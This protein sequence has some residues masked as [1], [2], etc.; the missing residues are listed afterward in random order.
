[1][2]DT[3][4]IKP[5]ES[6]VIDQIV[7]ITVLPKLDAVEA[8]IVVAG[9]LKNVD[10]IFMLDAQADCEIKAA[11][12]RC[13]RSVEQRFPFHISEKYVEVERAE[14]DDIGF[15]DKM[16]DIFPAIQRNLLLN[17]PM[18]LLCDE[19]CAG[20]CSKCGRNLNEGDCDCEGEINEQFRELLDL[21]KD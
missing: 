16:I 7:E 4:K 2:I 12:S 1:M 15:S 8:K 14:G 6:I 17:I 11:C 13:L 19:D 3:R 9:R 20:L 5:N 18:K 10:D 21:F